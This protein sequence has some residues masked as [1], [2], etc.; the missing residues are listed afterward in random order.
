MSGLA[1]EWA[2]DA[3][4]TTTWVFTLRDGVT[5]HDGSPFNAE[6]VVW[7]LDKLLDEG[8]EQ[9]DPRQSAQG[10]SRIPAIA[11]YRAIDDLTLEITTTEPDATLPYQLAWIMMSSKANWEAQD[12][13][14]ERVAQHP[15]GTGPWMLATFMP[16]EQA[17]LIPLP[18]TGTTPASPSWTSWC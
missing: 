11:G 6:N 8:S 7:N 12:K 14:W 2:V 13:D 9:Y 17:E 15:S 18:N 16:R 1:T 5:F 3:E 10:K 4:D